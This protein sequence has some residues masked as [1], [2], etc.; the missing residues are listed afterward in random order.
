MSE[1]ITLAP[2]LAWALGHIDDDGTQGQRRRAQ[3]LVLLCVN[4]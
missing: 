3:I 4:G 1:P 2:G